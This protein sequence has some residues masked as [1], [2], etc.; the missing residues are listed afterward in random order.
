MGILNNYCCVF[1]NKKVTQVSNKKVLF[2][3]LLPIG[4]NSVC[5]QNFD[6]KIRRDNQKIHYEHRVYEL[7]DLG[8]PILGCLSITDE[9]THPTKG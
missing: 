4:H 8:Y 7:V 9:K 1:D 5:V 3:P 2:N 6:F